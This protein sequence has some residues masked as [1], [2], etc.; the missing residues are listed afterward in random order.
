MCTDVCNPLKLVSA[1]VRACN[2]S[3]QEM[4]VKRSVQG[5]PWLHNEFEGSLGYLRLCLKDKLIN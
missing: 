3:P 2:L 1:A 5:Q 4:E